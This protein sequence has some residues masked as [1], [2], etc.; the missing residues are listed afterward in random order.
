MSERPDW[1]NY[2]ALLIECVDGG[3]EDGIKA[4]VEP[5]DIPQFRPVW[6]SWGIYQFN[7]ND[8]KYHWLDRSF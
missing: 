4:T 7:P 1:L 6:T 2:A 3:P 5:D 8:R